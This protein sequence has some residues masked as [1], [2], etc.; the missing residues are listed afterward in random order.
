MCVCVNT[1]LLM[2]QN[3]AL[4]SQD[5]IVN[6]KSDLLQDDVLFQ[7]FQELLSAPLRATCGEIL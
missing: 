2:R 3:F 6:I 1:Q 5:A 4:A 7:E